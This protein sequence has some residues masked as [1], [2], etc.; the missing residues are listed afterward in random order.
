MIEKY[1]FFDSMEGDEREYSEV[2][3]ARFGKVL[4]I[5]GVRGGADA[6]KVA[7]YAAGLAVSVE[8]GYAMV[9]G[10][11]Y[12]LEDDGTGVK[13]L[14]LSGAL[15]NPRIDRIVLR[16]YYATRTIEVGVLQGEEAAQPT[17]P[18]LQRD[19]D[20]YML[21]LAQVRIGVAAGAVEASGVTDERHD[22]SVCGIMIVS[23]DAAMRAAQ[24]AQTTADGA[25][26]AA[27]AAQETANNANARLDN[28]KIGVSGGKSGNIVSLDENGNIKDSGRALSSLGTGATYSLDGTVL[29]ITTLP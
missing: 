4:A 15:S 12:A 14:S 28:L 6:L 7:A 29:T 20:V 19:S 26:T 21:S 2:D 5:D 10:R 11:Y 3:F 8:P 13:I 16:L 17:P 27:Q 25:K 9:Q 1:G 18:A 24:G 22:E 23:A